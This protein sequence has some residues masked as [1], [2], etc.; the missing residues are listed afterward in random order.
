MKLIAHRGNTNG[1]SLQENEPSYIDRA[2]FKGF[3]VEI[4]VRTSEGDLWLGHDRPQ[5]QINHD[6]IFERSYN[7]L[8]HAKDFVTFTYFIGLDVNVFWHQ[9][10]NYALTSFNDV[11]VYPG[12]NLLFDG[13]CIV[14][15]RTRE[16]QSALLNGMIVPY[17]ICSDFVGEI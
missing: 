14:V 9:E 12:R 5:Y 8:I 10:D 3:D 4:D 17:G 16:E 7:L 1:T 11:I 2:I 6:F 13:K 15:C